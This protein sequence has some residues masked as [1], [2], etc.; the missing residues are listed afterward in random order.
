MLLGGEL[1]DFLVDVAAP[2]DNEH[3]GA[4]LE[5]LFLGSRVVADND[6]AVFDLVAVR[7][8]PGQCD[9]ADFSVQVELLVVEDEVAVQ[10]FGD[11]FRFDVFEQVDAKRGV[12]QGDDA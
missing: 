7:L 10:R 1:E 11:V 9:D 4:L 3:A 2:D 6:D 5:H 8:V 12:G